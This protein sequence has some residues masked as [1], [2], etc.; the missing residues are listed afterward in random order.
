MNNPESLNV[1]EK[2]TEAAR[3]A[4]AVYPEAI[5]EYIKDQLAVVNTMAGPQV[6]ASNGLGYESLDAAMPRLKQ[7]E[8]VGRLFSGQLDMQNTDHDMYLAVRK[9]NPE[10]F[11]LRR[12]R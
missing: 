10:V 11:G 7:D 4:G 9:H 12:G 8:K 1:I 3:K 5:A 6:M 2:A